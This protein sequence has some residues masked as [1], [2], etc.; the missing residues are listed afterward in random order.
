[1]AHGGEI[2]VLRPPEGGSEFMFV[3]PLDPV[4]AGRNDKI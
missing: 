2:G 4:P 1:V 3:V